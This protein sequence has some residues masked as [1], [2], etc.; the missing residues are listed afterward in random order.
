MRVN[1]EAHGADRVADQRRAAPRAQAQAQAASGARSGL[2]RSS[3]G[4][5]LRPQGRIDPSRA[6]DELLFRQ[7]VDALVPK[8]SRNGSGGSD[9]WRS[10]LV[11]VMAAAA[12]AVSKDQPPAGGSG[13]GPHA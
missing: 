5:D 6:L 13:S 2:L 7:M 4:A 8:A 9:A 11:D 12:A 3:S 10:M 1:T